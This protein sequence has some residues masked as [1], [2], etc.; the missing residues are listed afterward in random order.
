MYKP[1]RSKLLGIFL[2]KLLKEKNLSQRQFAK[3]ANLATDYV[4]KL[5]NGQIAEP[6]KEIRRKIAQGLGIIEGEFQDLFD[7]YLIDQHS[8]FDTDKTQSETPNF[9]QLSGEVAKANSDLVYDDWGDA[10]DLEGFR[11]RDDEIRTLEEWIVNDL[12]RCRLVAVLGMGGMGKTSIAAKVA[13]KIQPQFDYL[14]W[15]SLRNAPP[16]NNIISQILRFLLNNSEDYS[17]VSEN[18]KILLLIN[19]LRKHRCLIILDNVESVLRSGEGKIQEWAGEYE[20]GYENYGYF[21]KKIAETSHKSCL[22]LTSREKPKELAVLEGKNLRVK[23]LQ[24]SSINLGE[25]REILLDKGCQC[26]DK[27][28]EELVKRYSGNPLALKI[29]G[30]TVY[31]LFSNNITEFLR[32]IQEENAVYGDIQSLLETQFNRLSDIEKQVMYRLAIHREY[33]SLAQL[34]NDLRTTDVESKILEVVESL[35]RRSLIEKEANTSRF[36]QQS[37]V[38]EYVTKSYIERVTHEFSEK[39]NL[40]LFMPILYYKRDHLIISGK[41]KN[42]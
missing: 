33:L 31:D 23:F 42:D 19:V 38:M 9:R 20:P 11:G 35:L 40:S 3:Q 5:V 6:R 25:S 12:L 28:L 24:L 41:H 14:I 29:V 7:R 26:T 27:Q 30:T 22:L 39:K 17:T 32:E 13:K 34:K 21:F 16:L 2:K 1:G 10:I 8:Y 36:R 4:S 15:R 37:V 18:E